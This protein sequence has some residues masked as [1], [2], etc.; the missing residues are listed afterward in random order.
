[1]TSFGEW[2]AS[3]RKS[4]GL[5]QGELAA[6]LGVHERSIARYEQGAGGPPNRNNV[7][8]IAQFFSA[9]YDE[10]LAFAMGEGAGPDTPLRLPPVSPELVYRLKVE[11]EHRGLSVNRWL[12]I[13]LD[14]LE[15]LEPV[16]RALVEDA[17]VRRAPA[18]SDPKGIVR[19]KAGRLHP[20]AEDKEH[21]AASR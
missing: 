6:Q 1:M 16:T 8:R 12:E 5:T 19:P 7:R 3:K 15:S 17:M 11:A 20:A 13:I 9:N 4:L 2:L 18:A 21:A 14:Y 10:L